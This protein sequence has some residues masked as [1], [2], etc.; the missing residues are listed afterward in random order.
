M[1]F[2]SIITIL[3]LAGFFGL[4]SSVSSQTESQGE[5]IFT[6]QTKNFYPADFKGKSLPVQNSFVDISLELLKNSKLQDLSLADITWFLD[7]KVINRGTGN[8]ET[9]FIVKKADSDSH[10][11]RVAVKLGNDLHESSMRLYVSKPKIA[12]TTNPFP[13][14]FVPPGAELTLQAIPYFFNINNIQDLLFF[15]QINSEKTSGSSGLTVSFP[16]ELSENN[17]LLTIQNKTDILEIAKE[18]II[19]STSKK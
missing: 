4:S 8:N 6:W 5:I 19:L 14:S 11:I 17:I 16:E 18:K 3:V 10:F 1:K 12:I 7:E 2:L 15:W 9:S 13:N